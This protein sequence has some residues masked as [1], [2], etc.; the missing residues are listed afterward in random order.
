MSFQR[1]RYG[2]S[3]VALEAALTLA[4]ENRPCILLLDEAMDLLRRR[5]STTSMDAQ[6]QNYLIAWMNN[7]ALTEAD[8][9]RGLIIVATANMPTEELDAAFESRFH[10]LHWDYPPRM[11]VWWVILQKHGFVVKEQSEI[12]HV[13]ERW[14]VYDVRKIEECVVHA[15]RQ[16]VASRLLLRDSDPLATPCLNRPQCC[17]WQVLEEEILRDNNVRK[18]R[19]CALCRFENAA[20]VDV[21]VLS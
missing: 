19:S 16:L 7:P 1:Y 21:H 15:C 6:I 12:A 11:V 5:E 18:V 20:D 2:E 3:R 9:R 17:F 10:I 13:I 8:S 14:P 4:M